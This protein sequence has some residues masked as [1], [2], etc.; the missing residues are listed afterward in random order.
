MRM[1]HPWIVFSNNGRSSV[2]SLPVS[3]AANV[4]ESLRQ[5]CTWSRDEKKSEGVPGRSL[6]WNYAKEF[7]DTCFA[8]QLFDDQDCID[9]VFQKVGISR[10]DIDQY[11]SD[12][13]GLTPSSKT[14]RLDAINDTLEAELTL[15]K[16]HS[17]YAMPTIH[18]D[19][20]LYVGRM[21]AISIVHAVCG[22]LIYILP[23]NAA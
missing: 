2:F 13:G 16:D 6:W 7:Y 3:G 18:N 17:I 12:S 19:Q 10:H 5:Q 8:T 22:H 14:Q 21:T 15:L 20:T 1:S 11:M 9:R 4:Q 23:K